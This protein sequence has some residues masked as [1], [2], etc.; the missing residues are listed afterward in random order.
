[1]PKE[2]YAGYSLGNVRLSL[3]GVYTKASQIALLQEKGDLAVETNPMGHCVSLPCTPDT[4]RHGFQHLPIWGIVQIQ[5]P[6]PHSFT[7]F[8]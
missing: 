2:M 8:L 3:F 4:C 1:M 5:G 6:Q 7:T